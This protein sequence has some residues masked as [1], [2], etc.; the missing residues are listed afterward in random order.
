M[1][2]SVQSLKEMTGQVGFHLVHLQ[3]NGLDLDT[4][5]RL[6][7]VACP[8]ELVSRLQYAVDESMCGDLLRGFWKK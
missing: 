1:L 7:G 8:K 3:T 4:L 5:L 2:F 6:N